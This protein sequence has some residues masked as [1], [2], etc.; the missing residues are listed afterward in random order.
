MN[1][2]DSVLLCLFMRYNE[3]CN[4]SQPPPTTGLS[5]IQSSILNVLQSFITK[6]QKNNIRTLRWS[7]R[8]ILRPPHSTWQPLE[9]VE[10]NQTKIKKNENCRLDYCAHLR[11]FQERWRKCNFKT[12]KV[13][14]L[15]QNAT[16]Y[17]A[18]FQ[19]ASCLFISL[20]LCVHIA[21]IGSGS[22]PIDQCWNNDWQSEQIKF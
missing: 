11:C 3:R 2:I 1:I 8:D 10:S 7:Q 20:I 18:Y 13:C 4:I 14:H 12:T 19:M 15:L 6:D 5:D 9:I 16:L 17:Y 22:L 21:F